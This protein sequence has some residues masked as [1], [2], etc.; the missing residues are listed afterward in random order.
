MILVPTVSIPSVYFSQT[1]YVSNSFTDEGAQQA[2]FTLPVTMPLTNKWT[3]DCKV[4]VDQALLDEY[5][6][7][8][9]RIIH[10]YRKMLIC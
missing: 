10:C 9:I 7:K 8:M 2:K 6:K 5:N 4:E 3:F 1:G